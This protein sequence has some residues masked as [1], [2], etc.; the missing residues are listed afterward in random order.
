MNY[1]GAECAGCGNKFTESDDI[2]VC[3]E[4]GTPHHRK[5]YRINGECVNTVRHNVKFNWNTQNRRNTVQNDG[6]DDDAEIKKPVEI[7]V[8]KIQI[9]TIP[10]FIENN[11]RILDKGEKDGCTLRE[12][13]DFVN[14]N[15]LYYMPVFA[16]I[17]N[18]GR[19]LSFNLICFIFPQIYFANRKMWFWAVLTSIISVVLMIPVMISVLAGGSAYDPDFL[20]Q[21][22]YDIINK[23]ADLINSLM[24]ICS[25][26]DLIMRILLCLFGNK[27]YY[28]FAVKS[29]R[30]IKKAFG[31]DITKEQLRHA[32]GTKTINILLI[33]LIMFALDL[34][35]IM[36][37]QYILPIIF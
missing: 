26:A 36:I 13:L 1:T 28:N 14:R 22:T 18:M 6:S 34:C 33:L 35:A 9:T 30:R 3:P 32:G 20:P 2:V 37:L 8:E 4:C 10:E 19:N 15:V 25:T 29:I 31:E 12:V 24:E 27:L 11:L 23:N 21:S 16:R 17:R 5:C 7:N